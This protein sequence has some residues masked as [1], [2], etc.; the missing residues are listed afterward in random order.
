MV[1]ALETEGRLPLTALARSSSTNVRS[2]GSALMAR[3]GWLQAPAG[4][5][6]KRFCRDPASWSQDPWVFVDSGL[7]LPDQPPLLRTRQRLHHADARDLW[8]R[9]RQQGWRPVPPQ[10]GAA[11]DP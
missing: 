7:P 10:W 6:T 8:R 9:L 4:R 2:N 1:A 11:V 3:E 5:D